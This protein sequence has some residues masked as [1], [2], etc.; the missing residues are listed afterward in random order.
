MEK[1][2]KRKFPILILV[3]LII[4]VSIGYRFYLSKE[5]NKNNEKNNSI[6]SN[7]NITQSNNN[8]NNNNNTSNIE[9][10]SNINSNN[11]IENISNSNGN[12]IS[13]SNMNSNNS[14]K[15]NN[16]S[17]K[18]NRVSSI[19]NNQTFNKVSNKTSNISNTSNNK[20]LNTNGSFSGTFQKNNIKITIFQKGSSK[21]HYRIVNTSTGRQY[22]SKAD[23]TNKTAIGTINY[24]YTFILNSTGLQL[25]TTDTNKEL[26]GNYNKINNYTYRDYYSDYIGEIKYENSI[27][28]GIFTGEKGTIK[29][30]QANAKEVVINMKINNKTYNQT[31]DIY[32]GKL[33]HSDVNGNIDISISNNTLK[34]ISSSS[35]A[36]HP[37]FNASGTYTKSQKYTI[38]EIVNDRF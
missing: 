16:P 36:V 25:S 10:I 19:T 23:I 20:S 21:M 33:V 15:T 32:N 6:I 22:I 24:T 2:K 11:N 17:N 29:L 26:S 7:S 18:S 37:L 12:T 14:N 4:I 3:L 31:L 35:S 8:S 27:Y 28:N 5:K 9:N 38:E 30:Y 13:N 34:V 1:E